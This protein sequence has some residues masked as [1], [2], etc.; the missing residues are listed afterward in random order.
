MGGGG[1]LVR[2][3]VSKNITKKE[4]IKKKEKRKTK[5]IIKQNIGA[6]IPKA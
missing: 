1:G 5:K 2:S 6:L 4:R 3:S